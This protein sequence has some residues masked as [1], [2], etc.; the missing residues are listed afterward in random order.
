M[1]HGLDPADLS[2]VMGM[3]RAHFA[4]ALSVIPLFVSACSD[5]QQ[6]MFVDLKQAR[7]AGFVV[8]GWIPNDLPE[9]AT[10]LRELH[11]VDTNEVWGTFRL[12]TTAGGAIRLA[13]ADASRINALSI[14]SPNVDWWPRE[15]TGNLN[16]RSLQEHG[17]ELYSTPAPN[18][19]WVAV[20]RAQGRGFFWSIPR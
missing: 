19:F 16:A 2:I 6:A 18:A 11:D 10:E 17:F 8:K 13:L 9:S 1:E 12:P 20:N 14:R 7:A 4:I 5:R 15:L 3:R